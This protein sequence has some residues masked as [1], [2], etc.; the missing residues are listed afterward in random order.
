VSPQNNEKLPRIIDLILVILIIGLGFIVYLMIWGD[1]T[2]LMNRLGYSGGS[3]II[4]GVVESVDAFGNDLRDM[5]GG[6]L[7]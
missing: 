6:M 5:L 1:W 2:G 3:D 4:A 7:P